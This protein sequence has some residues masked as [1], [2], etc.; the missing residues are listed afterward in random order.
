[1]KN[2][3]ITGMLRS[4]TTLLARVLHHHPELEI[5]S[6]PYQQFYIDTKQL[7]YQSMNIHVPYPLGNYFLEGREVLEEFYYFLLNK[8]SFLE[9]YT[10][11][12]Q[13]ICNRSN[14]NNIKYCGS[15]EVLC[16]EYLPFILNYLEGSKGIIIIRDPRD[17]ITSL[18]HGQYKRYVGKLRPVLF[19]IR[20]WRKSVAF[21]I[22]L[23]RNHN[24]LL[25]RY[26]ELV[27]D[28]EQ[29]LDRIANF[30]EIKPFDITSFLNGIKDQ[31]GRRWKGN[32]SFANNNNSIN[33]N[34][35]GNFR[36]MLPESVIKYIEACC[37]PEMKYLDYDFTAISHFSPRHIETFKEPYEITRENFTSDY[38]SSSEH[39][40]QEI[41][42]YDRLKKSLTK[43]EI[44]KW[45]IFEEVFSEFQ[46]VID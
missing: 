15:K 9:K 45:Y 24:F 18:N 1:M 33:R 19:N 3:F 44:L 28:F 26:E 20:N 39:I 2:I 16:E 23:Q 6:Q 43:Q 31:K 40:Y 12:M 21:A 11:L 22:Y 35:I 5:V 13:E 34:S 27:C 41:E 7:F 38:S 29:S 37:Y 8:H 36:R 10:R 14:K 32:S 30:L 46:K 4:G 25:I 17:M 42:R